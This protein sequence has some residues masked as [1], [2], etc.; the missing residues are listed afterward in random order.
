MMVLIISKGNG[1]RIK[2]RTKQ[3]KLSKAEMSSKTPEIRFISIQPWL[4]ETIPMINGS[5]KI[6]TEIKPALRSPNFIGSE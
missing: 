5:C 3:A 6:V 2:N 1:L 4:M